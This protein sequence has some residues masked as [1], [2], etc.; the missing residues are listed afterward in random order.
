MLRRVGV[1]GESLGGRGNRG[2]TVEGNV[3]LR[4]GVGVDTLPALEI[5]KFL[6]LGGAGI[7]QTGSVVPDGNLREVSRESFRGKSRR[8]EQ[9]VVWPLGRL[10][11]E[12]QVL[13]LSDFDQPFRRNRDLAVEEKILLIE[14]N[15]DRELRRTCRLV[16]VRTI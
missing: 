11:V 1:D 8:D 12:G 3:R 16:A 6:W 14:E 2:E 13:L 10:S 15:L 9:P 4:P 7:R 5:A